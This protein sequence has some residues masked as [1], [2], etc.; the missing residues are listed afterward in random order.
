VIKEANELVKKWRRR[1]DIGKRWT[2]NVVVHE[3][4]WPDDHAGE[5]AFVA[6]AHGYKDVDLHLNKPLIIETRASLNETIA[7]E[8]THVVLWPLWVVYR[9]TVGSVSEEAAR[10]VNESITDQITD[11]L[12][13]A[14]RGR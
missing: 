13:A 8:L 2:I 11:A 9:D 7:H 1:L 4:T 14:E 10:D 5:V 3:D 12:L 6:V